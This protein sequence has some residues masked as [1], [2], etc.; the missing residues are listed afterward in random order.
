MTTLTPALVAA[1]LGVHAGGLTPVAAIDLGARIAVIATAKGGESHADS[2]R[3]VVRYVE[4]AAKGFRR[5]TAPEVSESR[6][7]W[8]AAPAWKLRRDLADAPVLAI[9]GGGTWQGQTCVW[10]ALVELDVDAP[11]EVLVALTEHSGDTGEG[12]YQAEMARDGA[13]LK[14]VYT[15]AING[16]FRLRRVGGRLVSDPS[17]PMDC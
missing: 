3:L 2:G 11:R 6:A 4:R 14:L 10:T 15:G 17:L 13:G 9:E 5:A 12:D 7:S 8:G 1:A 16:T